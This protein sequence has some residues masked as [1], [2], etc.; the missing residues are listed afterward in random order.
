MKIGQRASGRQHGA[1]RGLSRGREEARVFQRGR[2]RDLGVCHGGRRAAAVWRWAH[3]SQGSG[4]WW[5]LWTCRAHWSSSLWGEEGAGR[6]PAGMCP[7]L[8]EGWERCAPCTAMLV[9]V[10]RQSRGPVPGPAPSREE[11]H[12]QSLQADPQGRNPA[13]ASTLVCADSSQADG[14]HKAPGG[15][16]DTVRAPLMPQSLRE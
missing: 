5:G 13:K 8:S 1:I 11:A 4:C 16:G 2:R 15:P 14:P 3:L 7:G 10:C 9:A 6:P 12:T